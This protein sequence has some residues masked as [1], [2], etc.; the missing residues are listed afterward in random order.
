MAAIGKVSAVFTASTSGLT[1]GVNRASSSLKQL[2]ASTRSLQSGMRALVAIEATQF[3]A[4]IAST[5]SGY[6]SSLVRIGAAQAEAIDSTSKL[7]DRLGMTYEELAG[8]SLAGN[9]AGVSMEQIGAAATKADVAFAKAAN[10]SKTAVAAFDSIGLSVADLAGLNAADRFTAIAQA[11]AGVPGEAQRAAAAVRIFGRSGAELLPLF[12]SGAEAIGEA[13]RE[14]Q[15][16][17]LAITS[18]QGRGVEAMNDAITRAFE[19]VRGVTVQVVAQLA[20]YVKAVADAF[21]SQLKGIGGDNIGQAIAG[22][23]INGARYL[24]EVADFVVRQFRELYFAAADTLGI[25]ISEEAKRL[26]EMQAAIN[27]GTAPQSAVPGSG[28]FVTQLDPEFAQ[29]MQRLTD[30]VAAQRQTDTTFFRDLVKSADEA[31]ARVAVAAAGGDQAPVP[32]PVQ[33]VAVDPAPIEQAL[34][35]I[36]SRSTEGVSEMFRLMRGQGADVQQ[37][38][39][40]VLEQIAENTAG[41][42]ELLVAEF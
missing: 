23:L 3:F 2:E 37:Q 5:A 25:S 1:T 30:V 15:Q 4:G 18:A 35:G 9:L 36:D 28:G 20:P 32:P 26:K 6:V 21:T 10:G 22:A 39:L 27:A 11:I 19:A 31:L 12:N 8:L 33:I 24:A 41:G 17:G 38:Q 13:R 42:E 40:T 16:F 34:R 7:A 14:A 29:E